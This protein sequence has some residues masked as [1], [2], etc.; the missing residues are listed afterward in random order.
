MRI[1]FK[2]VKPPTAA[3]GLSGAPVGATW[4]INLCREDKPSGENSSWSLVER[5]FVDNPAE[6]GRC[7]F[8]R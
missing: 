2:A 3:Q 8:P 4:R 6:F 5:S 7:Y 1:P